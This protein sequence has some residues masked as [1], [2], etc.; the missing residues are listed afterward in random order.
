MHG[1]VKGRLQLKRATLALLH[2]VPGMMPNAWAQDFPR[3]PPNPSMEDCRTL[4]MSYFSLLLDKHNDIAACMHGEPRIG[5]TEE[6]GRPTV[7][8]WAQCASLNTE[9]CTIEKNQRDEYGTCVARAVQLQDTSLQAGENSL[10]NQE[11]ERRRAEEMRSVNNH[12]REAKES[13]DL[14]KDPAKFV[15]KSLGK[16][17]RE[18]LFQPGRERLDFAQEIY[19]YGFPQAR[20][21][22][23]ASQQSFIQNIRKGQLEGIQSLSRYAFNQLELTSMR[24]NRIIAET[25]A[26]DA[27]SISLPLTKPVPAPA[28]PMAKP[29]APPGECAFLSDPKKSRALKLR[30]RQRW[31]QLN[32]R[33]E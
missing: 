28:A 1:K 4:N 27:P 26:N 14:L 31:K 21:G 5:R 16:E 25:R 19:N 13:V 30:D 32:D 18:Q 3:S 12:Y 7:R 23:G 9:S 8:A 6:C 20:A 11:N 2:L 24:F 15:E 10:A 17:M 22:L 29:A 33:C